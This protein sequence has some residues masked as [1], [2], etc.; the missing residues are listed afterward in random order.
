MRRK[1]R[2]HLSGTCSGK[3]APV[4]VDGEEL[5]TQKIKMFPTPRNTLLTAVILYIIVLSK[6]NMT[7]IQSKDFL[8]KNVKEKCTLQ[9]QFH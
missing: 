3:A 6:Y 8:T 1:W 9:K 7:F 5:T 4:Q 2:E